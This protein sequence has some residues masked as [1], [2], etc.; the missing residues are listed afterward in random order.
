MG[1]WRFQI[2]IQKYLFH[3]KAM[4]PLQGEVVNLEHR[5]NIFNTVEKMVVLTT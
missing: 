5:Y 4:G 1:H 2:Q 3:L